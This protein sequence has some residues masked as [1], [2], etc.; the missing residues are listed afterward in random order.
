MTPLT[1]DTL[2]DQIHEAL[3]L[4]HRGS[5][6]GSPLADLLVYRSAQTEGANARRIT[7]QLLLDAIA[8]LE[9]GDAQAAAILRLRFADDQS[10][11]IVAN[12]L[13]VSEGHVFKKQREA[14][15]Q[16]ADIL[17]DTELAARS[18]RQERLVRRVE[19][20]TYSTLFG[21]ESAVEGLAQILVQPGPPWFVSVEGIGGIGKTSLLTAL[22]RRMIQ[23]GVVGWRGFVDLAWVTARQQLFNAGGALGQVERPALTGEQLTYDLAAQLL[24]EGE[25]A[26]LPLDRLTLAL[27]RRLKAAPHL[28][29]VDNLESRADMEAV[30]TAIRPWAN[31]TKF[32][33]GSRRSLFDASE[34]YHHR[35]PE[36]GEADVLALVRHEA[37]LRNLP[38]L[39]QADDAQLH[40]IYRTV[41]GNPLALRLVV[42]QTLVHGLADVMVDLKGAKGQASEHLYTYIYRRAWDKL[43]EPERQT[44]LL[45]PLINE[46]GCD[47]AYL[48]GLAE[49]DAAYLRPILNRLVSLNLVDSLGGLEARRYTIHSLTR[50]FLH[51]QVLQWMG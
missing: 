6:A 9:R 51:E 2:K 17:M 3:S 50:S 8:Q 18:E 16:L 31:P 26:G 23:E 1:T 11:Q 43:A 28:I 20:P 13:N 45:M 49:Q 36:L 29:V 47:L 37:R 27:G 4:W 15:E 5:L 25:G 7:N 24:P 34:L 10:A 14:I 32:L 22:V 46:N 35:L 44:L 21:M 39:A 48:A 38:A 12:R 42:G 30:L 33:L 19:L 41:G 40:A